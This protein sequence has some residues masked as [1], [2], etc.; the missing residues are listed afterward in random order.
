MPACEAERMLSIEVDGGYRIDRLPEVEEYMISL[1]G[2]VVAIVKR[3][4]DRSYR[5]V[6]FRVLQFLEAR[7]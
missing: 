1:D 3:G 7:Q 5:D 4:A 2:V 6:L